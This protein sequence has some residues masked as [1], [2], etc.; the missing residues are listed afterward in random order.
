MLN[1][2][3]FIFKDFFIIIKLMSHDINLNNP[4]ALE[5]IQNLL[6]EFQDN[7]LQITNINSNTDSQENRYM[8]EFEFIIDHQ[9]NQNIDNLPNF[10]KNSKEINEILG[11]AIC[12]K[13]NDIDLINKEE[14]PICFEPFYYKKYK[15]KLSCC[16]NTYH[17][18]CIDKW[19][20]KNSSCP[21]CRFDFLEKKD[22]IE[23]N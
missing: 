22:N 23:E 3:F 18:T 8:I 14:C 12:I 19:L 20:K 1:N 4:H 9:L 21:N 15:R 5:E 10:F 6:N 11:K 16:S 7:I 13:K 2:Y 17:K